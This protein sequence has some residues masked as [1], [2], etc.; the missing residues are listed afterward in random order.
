MPLLASPQGGVA[1]GRGGFPF[2]LPLLPPSSLLTTPRRNPEP[3]RSRKHVA[4]LLEYSARCS[5]SPRAL[6]ILPGG[7]GVP[8]VPGR[9]T[10]AESFPSAGSGTRVARERASL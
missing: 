8:A 5:H 7:E 1:E 6:Q 4:A 3:S 9:R 10:E 2:T